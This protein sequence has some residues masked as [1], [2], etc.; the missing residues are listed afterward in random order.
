[1]AATRVSQRGQVVIPKAI[2]ERLG[3]ERGQLLEVQEVEGAILMRPRKHN[4]AQPPKDWRGWGSVLK[5]SKALQDLETEHRQESE[6]G[7]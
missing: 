6:R 7:R 1:M 4:D 5:G 3:I 2:R